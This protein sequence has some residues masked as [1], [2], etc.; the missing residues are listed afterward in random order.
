MFIDKNYLRI[1]VVIHEK[2]NYCNCFYIILKKLKKWK[3]S[4]INLRQ[5]LSVYYISI[6]CVV[7][8]I[9]KANSLYITSILYIL[10]CISI[11]YIII[12]I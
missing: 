12:Y 3:L 9:L 11:I 1:S 8:V 2:M 5:Y 7:Y 10:I 6:V 4:C